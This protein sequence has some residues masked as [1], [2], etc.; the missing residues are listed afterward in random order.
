M[1]AIEKRIREKCQALLAVI[2]FGSTLLPPLL[3]EMGKPYT[4][5]RKTKREEA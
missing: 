3:A 2:L 4:E 5:R 1:P